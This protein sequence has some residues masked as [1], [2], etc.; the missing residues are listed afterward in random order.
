MFY[1]ELLSGLEGV[2]EVIS[3]V[4][5]LCAALSQQASEPRQHTLNQETQ[6]LA[7]RLHT[8]THT[9]GDKVAQLK[10]ADHKWTKLYEQIDVFSDWLNEKEV[11]LSQVQLT[12]VSPDLQLTKAKVINYLQQSQHL[13]IF[14][15]SNHINCSLLNSFQL[16][17]LGTDRYTH[18]HERCTLC[19]DK[20]SILF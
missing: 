7:Q 19:T 4:E 5:T 13:L 14:T 3:E 6:A 18:V 11:N 20:S 2:G 15:L 16:V 10:Q 8:T 17:T 9:I 1:Q 12:Q